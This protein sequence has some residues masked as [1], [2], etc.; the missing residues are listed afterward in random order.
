MKVTRVVS[1]ILPARMRN[2]IGTWRESRRLN[3]Q[4]PR[5]CVTESLQSLTDFPL[6]D[7]F[8]RQDVE[9]A[10]QSTET[11]LRKFDLPDSTGGVNV[12]DR[13]AIFYLVSAFQ[14]RDV[15][16]I[17]THIGA[18]T[19]HISAALRAAELCSGQ[20]RHLV[21]VDVV[22]VNSPVDR[23]WEAFGAAVAPKE[24]IEQLGFGSMV[25]FRTEAS[26]RFLGTCKRKFDFIFLDGDHSA[27]T[28]YQEIPAALE[29]LRPGGVILLHD[30]FPDLRPLWSNG[31]VIPGPFLATERL[32]QEGAKLVVVPLGGLPWPTKLASNV[33]SLALLAREV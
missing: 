1:R 2:G 33:T 22:D 13:R 19:V 29:L 31:T 27:Q 28:V 15:L 21:T 6:T 9:G 14:P 5:T 7:I 16:E 10:W 26:L 20:E 12:G 11:T 3:L 24:M 18:S 32:R 17:G 8:S 23:H 4:P 30:Y 25:E